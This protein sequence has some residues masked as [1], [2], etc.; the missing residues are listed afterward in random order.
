VQGEKN[1]NLLGIG[2]RVG[3]LGTQLDK[4]AAGFGTGR[5]CI[6]LRIAV[7]VGQELNGSRSCRC[8]YMTCLMI[9]ACK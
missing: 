4:R 2:G 6:S 1:Q 7:S 5:P 3:Q 9:A 8:Q